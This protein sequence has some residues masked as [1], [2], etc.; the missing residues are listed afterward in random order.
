[1]KGHGEQESCLRTPVFKNGK[2][3]E[4]GNHWSVSL[5]FIPGKLKEHIIQDII[6]KQVKEKKVMRSSQHRFTRVKLYLNN[7]VAF[8]NVM[9]RWV[10]ERRALDAVYLD[11]SMAFDTA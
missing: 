9:T 5:T 11:I 10:D 6:S 7:Q 4:P 3:K 1:M 8:Y 2:M